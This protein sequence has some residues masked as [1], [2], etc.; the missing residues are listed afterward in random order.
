MKTQGGFK[1][2]MN[3]KT[4]GVYGGL[5][6]LLIL[7]FIGASSWAADKDVVE[8]P[9]LR[10]H[11]SAKPAVAEEVI[12][13]VGFVHNRVTNNT[14][15]PGGTNEWTILFGDDTAVLPSMTWLF[16][17]TYTNNVYLYFGSLRVGRGEQ[18]VHFSTDTSPG[19]ETTSSNTDPNAVS[20]LDT[21]FE[22]SDDSPLVSPTDYIGIEAHAN[23]YAWSETYRDDFIIYDFWFLNLNAAA[24]EDIYIALHADCDVSGAGGGSGL[25]GFWR[26]DLVDFYRD[27]DAKEY[28]SYMYDSD[29]TS[30]AGDDTGGRNLPKESTGYIGSRLL[31]C[32]PHGDEDES[33]QAGHGWWDWNSDPGEDPDWMAFMSDGLWLSPPSSPHDFRFLQK[34]GP[35][36]IPPDDSIRLVFAFGVGE[37]LAGLRANLGWADSLFKLNWIGPSAPAAPTFTAVPGDRIVD[38]AWGNDSEITRDPATNALDFEGYRVWRRTGA[39][40]AWTL[41]M[42]CDL[43]N[44]I[45]FN[46]GLVHSYTDT[47]VNNGFQ[48]D[49]I[50]TAYDRG[51]PENGIESFESGRSG[52]ATVSHRISIIR[53]RKESSLSIYRLRKPRLQS[54]H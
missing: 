32:P 13:D 33:V 41:L 45:G 6:M 35:F 40:G 9:L 1:K 8:N 21:Y 3:K 15:L 49:Y 28:I 17:S 47:D 25:Q 10:S 5:I 18:L 4:S 7:T 43:V 53:P 44:D 42:E 14:V 29:N 2:M 48:Y 39:G 34:F 19:M 23:S 54:I 20:H 16:P 36:E 11:G 24:L 27:D 50:V 12:V 37:G 31:Y 30:I 22:L 46:T 38:L 26:D 51:E 52:F